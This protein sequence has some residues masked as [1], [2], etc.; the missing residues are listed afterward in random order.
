MFRLGIKHLLCV[1]G[2]SVTLNV[3]AATDTISFP[4]DPFF[5]N[6]DV[7]N[8]HAVTTANFGTITFKATESGL[9][10]GFASLDSGPSGGGLLWSGNFDS[11]M[12]DGI[13]V[14]SDEAN[15]VTHNFLVFASD[16][17]NFDFENFYIGEALGALTDIRAYGYR[18]GINIS[19]LD[20][21]FIS[22]SHPVQFIS[23]GSDFDNVDEV[24]FEQRTNGGYNV[25]QPGLD[26]VV[27]D[28]FTIKDAVIDASPPVISNVIIPNTDH[29]VD[30][31]VTV[32][33]IV[34]SDVDD[35]T[36]G[37]GGLSGEVNGYP[38]SNFARYNSSTYI[39]TFTIT[40]GGDDVD[41][42]S[43][44]PV[45][46]TLTDSLGNTSSAYTSAISQGN[47]AIYANKPATLFSVSDNNMDEDG[48][49][50]NLIATITNS[51][52]NQWPE[53]IV[54]SVTY[55]G[56][57]SPIID[58]I[59]ITSVTIPANNTTGITP[60]YGIADSHRDRAVNEQIHAYFSAATVGTFSSDVKAVVIN[61]AEAPPSVALTTSSSSISENGG[62][63]TFTA[64]LNHPTYENVAVDFDFNGTAAV[65]GSDYILPLTPITINAGAVSASF[66]LTAVDDATDD[67]T[68]SLIVDI[69][70]VTGGV[71]SE[72]GV[73]QQT[74]NIINDDDFTAPIITGITIANS[75]HKVG[76]TVTA[77]I[78]VS[79]DNDDYTIGSG[80]LL[81][82]INGHALAD[83]TKVNDATYNATFYITNGGNDVANTSDVPVAFTLTDSTGNISSIY[84][85]AISQGNDA[86]YANS[87]HVELTSSQPAIPENGGLSILTATLSNSLNNQWPVPVTAS[88]NYGGT[89]VKDTDYGGAASMTV[90]AFSS[91]ALSSLAS[92]SDTHYDALADESVIVGIDATSV[93][94]H[95]TL[96]QTITITDAQDVPTVTVTVTASE[97]AEDG[98][99]S[100]LIA[101]L[102]HPTFEELRLSFSRGGNAVRD[103]VTDVIWTSDNGNYDRIIIAPGDTTGS[104]RMTAVNDNTD[105]GDLT[106]TGG[107]CCYIGNIQ[108]V[109]YQQGFVTIINDDD[110]TPPTVTA[111]SIP[112]SSHKVG[113][114]VTAT[115][116]V[117]PDNDD[118]TSGSGALLGSINGYALSSL[119]KVNDSTYT[120]AFTIT[121][122]SNDVANT[123]DVPVSFT[124]KDSLG[125]ITSTYT[126]AISQSSDAI[127]ANSPHIDLTSGAGTIAEAAGS[128]TLTATLSNSLNNQW[129]VPV[130]A[131]LTYSGTAVKDTDYIAANSITV[132]A[133]SSTGTTTVVGSADTHYDALV[134]ESVVVAISSTLVGTNGTT[135]QIIT[136][137]DAQDVPT[138]TVTVTESEIA[139]DGGI[140][141]FIA[142]LSHPTFEELRLSFA[143]GG[144]AVRDN[145]TDVIWTSDN[146][147]YDRIII[148][149]GDTTGSF[150]MTAVN[151]NTDDGDLTV[152]GHL[153]CYIGNI[154]QEGIQSGLVT[155]INDDDLTGPTILSSAPTNG[156][157][158]IAIANPVVTLNF[159]EDV[160]TSMGS[161]SLVKLSDSS[162]VETLAI[163]QPNVVF[164]GDTVTI[165]FTSTLLPQESYGLRI[166]GSAI[167]DLANN[168]YA[169][170]SEGNLTFITA[171]AIPMTADD[172]ATVDEDATVMVD[173]LANDNDSEGF[174]QPSSVIVAMAPLHGTT[175]VNT[176]NGVITFTPDANFNG[177]D[178]FTYTVAD[179][180]GK[181]SES[182]TVT[183]TVDG[184]ND[185]PT[186]VNDLASTTEDTAVTLSILGN[187][188]DI[189][190]ANSID[191]S[192]VIITSPSTSGEV[193]VVTAQMV[194]DD[195]SLSEGQVIY[196]PD[197]NFNG[198][199]SFS[200]TVADT[201]SGVSNSATVTINVAGAN[202]APLASNDLTT[203]DE[204][205]AVVIDVLANDVDIEDTLDPSTVNA[206]VEPA[207]GSI[208]I[209]S[210]SGQITYTP[211]PDFH[212]SDSFSYTVK[213]EDDATSNEA[214]VLIT[215]N[216]VNDAP[217]AEDNTVVLLEDMT[218][219]I[220]VLGN[221]SDIDTVLDS[222]HV[223]DV[224][225]VAI[226]TMPTSGQ[227]SV[228]NVTGS[229]S[230]TPT[231]NFYG[232]DSFTYTAKDTSGLVSNVASVTVT[233][234][235]VNDLPLANNDS[236]NVDEDVTTVIDLLGNDQDIDGSLDLSSVV[237]MVNGTACVD[238][239]CLT[240]AG[241]VTDN[242]DG[243]VSYTPN[244]NYVGSDGF[245]YSVND[246]EAGTSNVASVEIN[247]T[248]TNDAPVIN[249]D[250][251]TSVNEDTLYSYLISASDIDQEAGQV[252]DVLTYSAVD[253]P[254]WLSLIDNGDNSASLSGTP[255][256]GDVG[257]HS[258]VLTV[259][260]SN[261]AIAQQSFTIS[262][263]N[264][265]DAPEIEVITD[266]STLEDGEF[267][268]TLDSTLF[269]DVDSDD[270][271]T[272][273][274]GELP[275]WLSFDS[276]TLVF[277]GVPTNDNVGDVT[278]TVI[279]TDL[280]NSSSS[281]EFTLTVTNE[282]DEPLA[283]DDSVQ[284]DSWAAFDIDVLS[285][286]ID[287]DGDQLIII[288][289]SVESGSVTWTDS[290][291]TYTPVN[292]FLGTA[293]IEYQISD[294]QGGS[295]SGLA[296]VEFDVTAATLPV[297]TVPADIEINS[298]ALLTKV[299]IGVATALDSAGNPIPVSLIGET[300]FKPGVTTALWQA[301]DS[302]GLTSVSS[303][304]VKVN[305]LISLGADQVTLE[306]S[307]ATVAVYLNGP[308][309]H[310]P[311]TI[312][313]TVSG[314]AQAGDD[315]NLT[316]G[317]VVIESGTEGFISFNT[318]ADAVTEGEETIVIALD[319]QLNRG[320][321]ATHTITVTENNVSPTV[322][323]FVNQA[324]N[325]R[326]FVNQLDGVV[327]VSS[328]VN[329]PNTLNQ[330]TYQWANSEQLLSDVD[331]DETSYS[332]DP[333]DILPGVYHLT[334]TV[335][336]T[337]DTALTVT[338]LVTLVVEQSSVMLG[339]TDTDNDGVS[340]AI[341]GIA[342]FDND[343]I[344]NYLDD[345]S[346]CNVLPETLTS[347]AEFLLE[348]TPGTCLRLGDLA[349]QGASGGAS[350]ESSTIEDSEATVVGG[351]FDFVAYGL[352]VAGQRVEIVI[353]QQQPIPADAI[354]RKTDVNGQWAT[355]VETNDD[356][357]F[358]TPG[359][360][361][362]CPPPG[363]AQWQA[364]L[365]EGSWCIQLMISDGG[366]NDADGLVNNS[367]V[368]PGGVAVLISNNSQPQAVN[369]MA[370]TPL[371]TAVTIDVLANDTDADADNLVINSA[372]ATF[373]TVSIVD[374]Q[375]V[376]QPASGYF[377]S[378]TIVYGI[379]DG[380]G[381]SS[382]ASIDVTVLA[383]YAPVANDDVA[384]VV[385]GQDVVIAVLNNDTDANGDALSVVSASAENG[386]ITI[387]VDN[388]ISYTATNNFDGI[389]T[390]SYSVQDIFGEQ[391]VGEAKVTVTPAPVTLKNSGGGSVF[392]LLFMSLALISYRALVS[393]VKGNK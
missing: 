89:A 302:E 29:V 63:V 375:L 197:A 125:N 159:N 295:A 373:G 118:Y 350:I 270:E 82:A 42:G 387:N 320:H 267:S 148:A 43:D 202:D 204:D 386:V 255:L 53:D 19:T 47:D 24:R 162:V 314:S 180:Q 135:S 364:G 298:S 97:I 372:S 289:A 335:T 27:F 178:S 265:N 336:S 7:D 362:Y 171:N 61:D 308:A 191:S 292:G 185:V 182:A 115:I 243:T 143:R 32:T 325:E 60:I 271:L 56:T 145:V 275:A 76:D 98:G 183:I 367:I 17:R 165:R 35:Y 293:A 109:G 304:L 357:L 36:T 12:T 14:T 146:G 102:N 374:S 351:L 93:G 334:V 10:V 40:D 200:Y 366:P 240:D 37:S 310:Y 303:Q 176:A 286:D 306:G 344:P 83:L 59:P 134:D 296:F 179:Q 4:S 44:V 107:L 140:S 224:T 343:G 112:N 379:S 69:D 321:S 276:E 263:A 283:L 75:A 390:I 257:E 216:S 340:D 382:S 9:G 221:D 117:S 168:P 101:T 99:T 207:N 46:I 85:T 256:N 217:V 95:G 229:I 358:S 368:D 299:D 385:S 378:D 282:N 248:N 291:L 349:L 126:T 88:L 30:D 167:T 226:V 254:D 227:V 132:A 330:Y 38:L 332:F 279:V 210:V 352:P 73:Q 192:S 50:V 322:A 316:D 290:I 163:V 225:S 392:M 91:T 278:V 287:I 203:T 219:I 288:G 258:I 104:F 294:Q 266:S 329:P 1:I 11:V 377:G 252:D 341:E 280:S 354:Y 169:G 235:S 356:Q 383:N 188:T 149:P 28:R 48:G 232:A 236:A 190:T 15:L 348:G 128:A 241:M 26:G 123:S 214:T 245:S 297:I 67:G 158:D 300:F 353:P 164:A 66:V 317:T 359:E 261:E 208:V 78:S 71:V 194:I 87:P 186:A 2:C 218:H 222:S 119:T 274:V 388:T 139:E 41:K 307:V 144:N 259:T 313:Y 62:T 113:D 51:L 155:I 369:D 338:E 333:T 213:D 114:T 246:D 54:L 131:N 6:F 233:V 342:D 111:V 220:N 94:T 376:Y 96:V 81:G 136:I 142:T 161:I 80:G 13:T 337:L 110:L 70:S 315:H 64:S 137:T 130:T 33:I 370:V 147:N 355:F 177:S 34:D 160:Q 39:A 198:S 347:S 86:I 16:G 228:D 381:G 211:N 129:P 175:S 154:Q 199:D 249:S 23:L 301:I 79:P 21:N 122:G 3:F 268:Y 326:F 331:S 393:T 106:V 133:F 272:V 58:Y 239:P 174:L 242:A 52:N 156:A 84:T 281:Q 22:N 237:I 250:A 193:T 90:A 238:T 339:D 103:N 360:Q 206:Q 187:D 262:V 209:D 141:D 77:I 384:E 196:N 151:D 223:V 49:T 5:G 264:A 312:P 363:D 153:C 74:V 121:E 251:I 253:L 195:A 172:T 305:P 273:T 205:N 173:V 170:L 284:Q 152:S 157:I 68:L 215:V 327:V 181:I 201:L 318:N 285:N 138:V 116:S 124:L 324:D 389:D 72:L 105:D 92:I 380:Q 65:N 319:E 25:G 345:I 269:S 391:S 150:R 231:E 234:T 108:Q 365:I 244:A 127:Y 361:G 277:S 230:Y 45:N 8:T 55:A 371:G 212:G 309:P 20:I 18:D 184:V 260:D 189:D 247:V 323:L 328:V 31:Q 346:E 57:A 166:D 100:D 311:L 120:A